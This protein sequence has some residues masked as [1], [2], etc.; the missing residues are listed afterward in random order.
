[1][2]LTSAKNKSRSIKGIMRI[3]EVKKKEAK[4]I[5]GSLDSFQRENFIAYNNVI[6]LKEKPGKFSLPKNSCCVPSYSAPCAIK[7]KKHWKLIDALDMV[8]F[9]AGCYKTVGGEEIF[10]YQNEKTQ[11]EAFLKLRSDRDKT[12]L[13]FYIKQ[14]ITTLQTP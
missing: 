3:R 8:Y 10:F 7:V 1:M 9:S 12:R 4:I 6:E 13:P 2:N 14:S 5:W 11:A